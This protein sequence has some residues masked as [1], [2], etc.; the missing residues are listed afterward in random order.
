MSCKSCSVKGEFLSVHWFG[1]SSFW[2][3]SRADT[4]SSIAKSSTSVGSNIPTRAGKPFLISRGFFCQYS[5]K[6]ISG[7]MSA[8]KQKGSLS[9]M[10][11]SF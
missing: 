5:F 9:V 4:P 6:K 10:G 8:G 7:V 2:A 3:I 1:L 11:V